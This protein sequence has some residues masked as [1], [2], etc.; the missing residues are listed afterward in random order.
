[1]IHDHRLKRLSAFSQTPGGGNPA[2]VWLDDALPDPATMQAIAAQLGYSETAFVAPSTGSQ[3][4]IRYFSP[5]C[6]VDFCGHA[7]IAAG[8]R[9]GEAQGPGDYQLTTAAGEVALKVE[10]DNGHLFANMTSVPTQQKPL[11][12]K[13]LAQVLSLLDWDESVL[14]P[15]IPPVLAFAGLWHVV[16]VVKTNSRLQHLEYNFEGM[17]ALLEHHG[18]TTVQVLWRQHESLFHSRNL[19]PIG[20]VHEDPATGA[21]A[22]ALG[23]YLRDGAFINTPFQFLITQ[24]EAMGRPSQIRVKV[25]TGGGIEVSGTAID[26]EEDAS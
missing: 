13:L 12:E 9:L 26:I 24:G 22:A 21:A 7:T 11:S 25:P 3:K 17:K 8:V 10:R 4:Q 5:L 20:G 18:I 19:F 2:G 14:D 1:M 6:E 23:G 16:I 15:R